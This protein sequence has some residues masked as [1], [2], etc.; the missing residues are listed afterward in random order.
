MS[1]GFKPRNIVFSAGGV[2]IIGHLGVFV[3]LQ[4]AGVTSEVT[5]WYG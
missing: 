4:E 2:R 1:A 5:N 3:A